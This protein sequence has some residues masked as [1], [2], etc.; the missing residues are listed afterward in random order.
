MKCL[1]MRPPRVLQRANQKETEQAEWGKFTF[2]PA[3][4]GTYVRDLPGREMLK[5]NYAKNVT[6]LQG[7]N[8]SFVL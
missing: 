8:K 4:D 6:I 7:H 3:I 1:Q 2:G 5:G